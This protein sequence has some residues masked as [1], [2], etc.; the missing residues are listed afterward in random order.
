MPPKFIQINVLI[1]RLFSTIFQTRRKHKRRASLHWKAKCLKRFRTQ[2]RTVK[3][4]LPT[5]TFRRRKKS[6]KRLCTFERR[7]RKEGTSSTW[8]SS[9]TRNLHSVNWCDRWRRN[10]KIKMKPPKGKKQS[11]KKVIY[12][13]ATLHLIRI[14]NLMFH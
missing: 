10:T 12:A 4:R 2:K 11:F 13:S 5:Q 1:F 9:L 7:R 8:T 14:W 3:T 6:T